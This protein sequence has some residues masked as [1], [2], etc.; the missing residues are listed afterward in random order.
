MPQFDQGDD[1]NEEYLEGD[2]KPLLVVHRSC[3]TSHC[4]EDDWL[5]TN[6]FQSTCTIGRKVCKF[7]VDSCSCENA[8]FKGVINKLALK[9]PKPYKLA[10]LKKRSDVTMSKWSLVN[11]LI[12]QNYIDH[13]QCDVV[14]MDAC[15]LLLRR[16]WQYNRKVTHDGCLNTY[17]FMY[18][19]IRLMLLLKKNHNELKL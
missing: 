16:P 9:H 1:V 13:V 12:R 5:H 2:S 19:S 10:W 14:V 6:I 18:N 11:F 3:L 8:I 4:I 7:V 15:H 17:S